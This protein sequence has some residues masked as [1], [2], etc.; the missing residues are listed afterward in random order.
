MQRITELDL[1]NLVARLNQ[2]TSENFTLSYAYSGVSL[3]EPR[4]NKAVFGCG[5]IPKRALWERM[6]AFIAGIEFE[7]RQRESKHW[8]D[9]STKEK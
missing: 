6:H 4:T 1:R 2:L 8:Q 5:H 3:L 7:R 9:L